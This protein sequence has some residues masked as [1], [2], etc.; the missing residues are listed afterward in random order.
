MKCI[1]KLTDE[2]FNL[3]SVTF[4]N[5]RIRYASRGIIFN[6]EGKIAI[7][8]KQN[9]NEYKLIGGGIEEDEDP[10]LAFKREALEETGYKVE[11]YECLG[12]FEEVKTHDNFKQTSYIYV[13]RVVSGKGIPNY[14]KEEQQENSTILWLSITNALK[15][16]KESENNL[17][18]SKFES[19]LSLYHTKFI[20]RRDY[21]ILRYFKNNYY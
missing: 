11:I 18:P 13:A 2:D 21:L 15:V 1:G 7:L 6:D 10:K 12:T 17:I 19:R 16:L 9:K 14:T 5:P 3:E 4:Q 20:V 8:Y